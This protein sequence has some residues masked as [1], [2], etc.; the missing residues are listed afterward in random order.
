MESPSPSIDG[1][2]LL[3]ITENAL[4]TKTKS[5]LAA[6]CSKHGL[7]VPQSEGRERHYKADY[8]ASILHFVSHFFF[9]SRYTN[10]TDQ[11]YGQK[12][13]LQSPKEGNEAHTVASRRYEPRARRKTEKALAAEQ[14]SYTL[15]IR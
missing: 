10:V 13:G 6:F 12:Q 11:V 1:K 7:V 4:K 2:P 14:E 15:V 3:N 9:F 8:V 5:T